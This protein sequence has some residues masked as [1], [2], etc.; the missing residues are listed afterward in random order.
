MSTITQPIITMFS[1]LIQKQL[2]P[3]VTVEANQ[4]QIFQ[5]C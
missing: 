4:V 2:F 5:A 3:E 1:L